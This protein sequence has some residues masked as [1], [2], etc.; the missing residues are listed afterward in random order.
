MSGEAPSPER[1][2][3]EKERL[4]TG[5]AWIRKSHGG[6][7]ELC[8]WRWTPLLADP[9]RN[10]RTLF[11]CTGETHSHSDELQHI[12]VSEIASLQTGALSVSLVSASEL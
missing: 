12:L 7:H 3:R 8:V 2:H 1:S 5:P 9:Y 10:S 6:H 4:N 11:S